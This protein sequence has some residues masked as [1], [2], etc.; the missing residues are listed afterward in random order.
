MTE[1]AVRIEGAGHETST[2]GKLRDGIPFTI[3]VECSGWEAALTDDGDVA[4][5]T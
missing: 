4:P 1:E 5:P 3:D 2:D